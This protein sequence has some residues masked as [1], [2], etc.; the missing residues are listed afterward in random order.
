MKILFLGTHGQKNWGDELMLNVFVHQLTPVTK[1][2][3]INSYEPELTTA[4]LNKPHVTVFNTKTDKLKLLAYL[5]HCDAVVFGGGNILK[6]L[7]TAY[8]GQKYSTLNMIDTVT[9]AAK[10]ARKPIY[11]CNIGVGPLQTDQGKNIAKNIL[12]RA[13]LTVVRDSQ[14]YS[15]LDK[16]QLQTSYILSSDAVFSVDRSYLALPDK[17]P[18]RH[19]KSLDDIKTVGLS[20]CRNISNNDNWQYFMDNL[21]QDILKLHR[22]NPKTK[23]VGIPMQFDVSNNN[24]QA[25][26]QDL[27]KSLKKDSPKIDFSIAKPESLPQLALAIEQCDI[28]VGERLHAL[29]LATIIGIPALALEYDVKV[30]GLAR[31]LGLEKTAVNINNK[32]K[33]GSILKSL[34]HIANNYPA[35]LSTVQ[36]AYKTSHKNAAESFEKIIQLLQGEA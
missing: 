27:A 10:L 22:Q 6:E 28:F 12:N 16:L 33:P 3:Y 35:A 24:D 29:I 4:Y 15:M 21:A 1:K 34:E 8:G 32:F 9:K 26:L 36:K 11:F 31:D 13:K 2:F 18:R 25:V 5:M 20:L 30:T 17:R 14:S 19:P 7:Y 23:F